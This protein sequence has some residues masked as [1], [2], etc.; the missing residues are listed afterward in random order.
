MD[1][2]ARVGV[3]ERVEQ[4]QQDLADPLPRQAPPVAQGS[5]A[6][7][8]HRDVRAAHRHPTPARCGGL[9]IDLADVVDPD[10]T[11]VIEASDRPDLVFER[12]LGSSS[13]T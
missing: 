3:G 1:H 11:G 6:R 9:G 8:L 2:P 7:V 12:L 10:H 4:G 13:V 5:P